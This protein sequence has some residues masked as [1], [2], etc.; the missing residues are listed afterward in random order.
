[1]PAYAPIT[2]HCSQW[3]AAQAAQLRESL[4][5]RRINHKFHYESARQVRQWLRLHETHSPARVDAEFATCY[6]PA[7]EFLTRHTGAAPLHLVGLGCGGGQKEAALLQQLADAGCPVTFSASD[8][9]PGMVVTT[10]QAAW[11]RL[12]P[13]C[14]SGLVC[15]LAEVG[16]LNEFLDLQTPAGAR[17]AVTF[18]GMIPNFEPEVLC[19]VLAGILRPGDWLLTSANLAPGPEYRTGVEKVL[20]QYDN[21]LTREWLGLLLEDLGI[22]ANEGDMTFGIEEAPPGSGLLRIVARFQFVSPSAATVEGETFAFQPGA[23]LQTF[24]SY[25]HTVASVE[26]LLAGASLRVEASWLSGTGEEG[27]FLAQVPQ[28]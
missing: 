23:S 7:F 2:I 14:C 24:F 17:R 19:V 15:D 4:R 27:V 28:P 25:R 12:D 26:R 5:R 13:R 10:M 8:V 22:A 3:P 20:P 16:D 9:S 18:F 11:E 6:R 1:M 21:E